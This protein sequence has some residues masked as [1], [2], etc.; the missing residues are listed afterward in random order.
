MNEIKIIKREDLVK[1]QNNRAEKEDVQKA[2]QSIAQILEESLSLPV[3]FKEV[4]FGTTPAIRAEVVKA[5][6]AAN[7]PVQFRDD[8]REYEVL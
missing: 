5:L 6:R 2:I 4:L 8:V 3:C 7:Y 1:K